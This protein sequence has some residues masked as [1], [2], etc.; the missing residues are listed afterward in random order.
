MRMRTHTLRYKSPPR[1]PAPGRPFSFFT[2]QV[3]AVYDTPFNGTIL[4]SP[5]NAALQLPNP[6]DAMPVMHIRRSK[7]F[8]GMATFGEMLY[9]LLE[10]R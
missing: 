8:E 7:G 9:P 3:E 1:P 4:R 10:V 6:M 5:D 2:L